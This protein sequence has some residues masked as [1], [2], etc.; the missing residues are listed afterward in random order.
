M[1]FEWR[2]QKRELQLWLWLWLKIFSLRL[3]SDSCDLE[4]CGGF[5]A[6]LVSN[7]GFDS[8]ELDQRWKLIQNSKFESRK[9]DFGFGFL[10]H[11]RLNSDFL[12]QIPLFL[13][14]QVRFPTK[15]I[16]IL[17]PYSRKI[18]NIQILKSR[19]R[20]LNPHVNQKIR[21]LPNFYPGFE[22]F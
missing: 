7:S 15:F 20:T 10:N 11:F 13:D 17:N 9:L 3:T 16:R 18:L 12:I 2:L 14:S 8:T 1:P 21:I 5:E 4:K 6:L 22:F 19:I